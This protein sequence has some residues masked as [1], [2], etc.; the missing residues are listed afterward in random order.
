MSFRICPPPRR[1]FHMET[2]RIIRERRGGQESKN[3][4]MV[5]QKMESGHYISLS[6]TSEHAAV[7]SLQ[8]PSEMVLKLDT[9]LLVNCERCNA[10][11]ELQH[12]R[13]MSFLHVKTFN[14]PHITKLQ[15]R[16]FGK[17][18]QL[19][20][21][22]GDAN[23]WHFSTRVS[24]TTG[25]VVRCAMKGQVICQQIIIKTVSQKLF[26]PLEFCNGL[27]TC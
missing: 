20:N 1:L 5:G 23:S 12:L 27:C 10:K 16:S 2:L 25:S 21:T 13:H 3:I 8:K 14:H 15:Y 6:S 4:H 26:T 9:T 18:R 17:V 7:E 11:M 19:P 24:R 22:H